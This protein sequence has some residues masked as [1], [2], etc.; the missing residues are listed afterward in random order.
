MFCYNRLR[1]MKDDTNDHFE[2]LLL[3]PRPGTAAAAATAYGIDLTLTLQNLR[4]SPE[5]RVRRLDSFIEEIRV[6]RSAPILVHS[7]ERD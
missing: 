4:L 5:D 7:D 1:N 3:N 6:L 2:E